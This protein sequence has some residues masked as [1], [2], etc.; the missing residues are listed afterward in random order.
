MF[1]LCKLIKEESHGD[2]HVLKLSIQVVTY[3]LLMSLNMYL[4]S[5]VLNILFESI[6]VHSA[7]LVG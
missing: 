3:M 7:V 5:S 4:A 2:V 1:G 6:V